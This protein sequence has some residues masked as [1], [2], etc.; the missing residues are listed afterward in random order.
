MRPTT[1]PAAGRSGRARWRSRPGSTTS[2][3]CA[4]PAPPTCSRRSPTPLACST[5]SSHEHDGGRSRG[6]ARGQGASR[7]PRPGARR[8]PARLRRAIL[9][10]EWYPAMDVLLEVEGEPDDIERAIVA[11]AVPRDRFLAESLPYFVAAYERRTGQA[12]VLA[13]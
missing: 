5:P 12:A 2:R 9:R 13:R 3:R 7:G 11:T 8:A 1:W 10:L 4:P 6:R